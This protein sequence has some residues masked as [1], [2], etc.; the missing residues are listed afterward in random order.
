MNL[1]YTPIKF[2]SYIPFLIFFLSISVVKA[3]QLAFPSAIGAGAYT[4][5]GRGG[6]VC[7]VD[8][9][10]WDT[11]VVYDSDTDSYSGGFYNMFYE[12]DIP[13]RYIV[14]NVS[15]TIE[16]PSG[17]NLNFK[18]KTYKGNITVAGQTSNIV[19]KTDYFM[20][21]D[22]ENLIWRYTSFY[23]GSNLYTADA[24]TI[25]SQPSNIG[26]VEYDH[27]VQ[28]IIFDHCSFF[29][30]SDEAFSVEGSSGSGQYGADNPIT[31]VTI[32]NCLMAASAKGNILGSYIGDVQNTLARNGFVEISHR[33]GNPLG[34][35]NSQIDMINNY[36]ESFG[37]RLNRTTG[38]GVFNIQNYYVR[39]NPTNYDSFRAQLV[40]TEDKIWSSG[41]IIEG[42]KDM[43]TSPDFDL[44]LTFS[45]AY[46]GVSESIPII[47]QLTSAPSLVGK[48]FT[49]FDANQL[50][51]EVVPNLG[52]NKRLGDDGSIIEDEF[53][54]D[55]FYKDLIT[56]PSPDVTANTRYPNDKYPEP[57]SVTPLYSTLKDGIS[58]IWRLTNMDGQN[59]NDI[60]P[61]GYT[62]LEE[63]LNGI[64]SE[65]TIV[66]VESVNVTPEIAE[67]QIPNTLQLSAVFTPDNVSN[68]SGVWTSS[69]ESIATVNDSGVLTPI[70]PGV[71]TITFTTNDGGFSDT[72]I[73]TVLPEALL[74]SAGIDQQICEGESTFLEASGGSSY[75][76][77]NGE[78]TAIIEV[79][80]SET[81]T[82]SVTVTDSSGQSDEASVT[83]TVI[84]IPIADLGDDQTICAGD[85]VILTATGG[86]SYLWG[87]GE[88]GDSIEVNPII[89]T[90]YEVEV[91]SN[92]CSSIDAVTI[93]VDNA[94][95]ISVTADLVMV[96]GETITLTAS[97]SDNYQWST[98]ETSDTITV[99]PTETTTYSVS[100]IGFNGCV[101][102]AEVTV[103]VIPEIVVYAGEDVTI[104]NGETVTLNASGG[105]T[106]FWDTGDSGPQLTVEPTIT[107]TYTVT[108]EDGYGYMATDSVTIFV[109]ET[110]E[111][112]VENT[113]YIMIGNSA[114][115][116][117]TGGE[118]YLWNTGETNASISVNPDVTTTY[119]VTGFSENG[120]ESTDTI[121][122]TVLDELSANAGDD[123]SICIG[124]S[125]VLNATGGITYTW[126]TG[127]NVASPTFSPIETTTYTVTVTDGFGNSDSDQVTIFVNTIPTAYAGEDQTICQGEPVTLVASGGDTYLWS[128]GESNAEIEVSPSETT[129]YTVEVFSNNCSN[130]DEVTV[131]TLAAPNISISENITIIEGESTLLLAE[132]GDTYTWNTGETSSS[133]TVSPIETTTYTV[134]GYSS[135]GCSNST[136]VTVTTIPEIIANAGNDI[137]ICSGESVTLNASG[138]MYYIWNTGEVGPSPTFSPTETTTYTVTVTDNF[139]NSDSDSLTIT[140]Y[141]IPNVTVSDN[142][143]ITEGASTNLYANGAYSYVWNTGEEGASITVSPMETTTYMVTGYSVNGCISN[144]VE[145]IVTVVPEVN[146]NAGNDISICSGETATLTA[147]GGTNYLWNNGMSNSSI[148]VS[149]QETTTYIV[150]VTDNYGNFDTDQVTVTVNEIPNI[151]VSENI[152]IV[153]GESTIL[154]AN[155][156]LSYLWS[157]D[158]TTNTINVSPLETTVYTVVGISNS[159]VSIEKEIV[160]TVTPLFIASAGLD[161][162]VCD[163]LNY[164]VVLTANEG[165]SYL[166]STGETSQSITVSP[167]ATTTYHV[168]IS[169]GTQEDTD[170]VTIY[171]E[172][173]PEVVIANGESVDIMNGDFITLSVSGANS[174][175]WNNGAS[176]PNIAV[177]PSVTTTYEVRGYIGDCYDDKQVTVNVLHPVE[178][179]AGED[180]SIC[181]DDSVILTASGGDD[182]LWST[183][184]ITASIEVSPLETTDYTVTVFNALD[185][186]EDMVTVEVDLDCYT[187][188]ENPIT[189]SEILDFNIFPNPA[190][191]EVNVKLSGVYEISDVHFFD[192][193]GKLV[194]KVKIFNEDL[195]PTTTTT[196]D[197]STLQS[198]IYFVKFIGEDKTG[199]TKKLIIN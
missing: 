104:C 138:G 8:T 161:E 120:C 32:Q 179:E 86:N 131:Y 147:S 106:Y 16:V 167:M 4:T 163:N 183:G 59:F 162:H 36:V 178:A 101:G 160:V 44:W 76:W 107:T 85:T 93:F 46:N 73:I 126:N 35:G 100:S 5:G 172:P 176:Q 199:L 84:A 48:S 116:T 24:L 166:W 97:G 41:H 42:F 65:V 136:Q 130:I 90:T 121:I 135:N 154:S 19:F 194:N 18:Y 188:I 190:N 34:F 158:E 184:E 197:I 28:N 49:I 113:V 144:E 174:Y 169:Q 196:I 40:S 1:N 30:G 96:E 55:T 61:S 21:T 57:T 164:E 165:D 31:N 80:P 182:Y 2:L 111:I 33:F 141:E 10:D 47:N 112:T 151:D 159:C 191:N 115:L 29:Y 114:T 77:S 23:K 140:V 145:L 63:Y 64:D 110:P 175:E 180:V 68:T 148:V 38:D 52:K 75:L 133:I 81:T 60:A 15:G 87:T 142:M 117:A 95:E 50:I 3:Q 109:N 20:I 105:L 70:S 69:E 122:V 108:A 153:E 92:G 25:K 22:V 13:A 27:I 66:G 12:L 149:P 189:V 155:G 45:G 94:P 103:T 118:T 195:N 54:L 7:Y 82:Y 157:T 171:V 74:V 143:V 26:G 11:A 6:K 192:V 146:A 119:T 9:L 88:T 78:T 99:S 185:F 127:D 43:P 139:G 124:E 156:A 186:D 177:S 168:T 137:S 62:W 51:S 152:T 170:S 72:S 187:Q 89:E 37:A 134:T 98:T 181:I 128:T 150:T 17:T 132:G 91:F 129:T 67:L 79:A 39:P 173:S 125:V 193:T 102:Y 71:V 123:V 83:V 198:G 58:D 53:A 14:F 56:N